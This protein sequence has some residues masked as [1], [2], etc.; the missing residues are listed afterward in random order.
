MSVL[1]NFEA[2]AGAGDTHYSVMRGTRADL[3]IRQSEATGW[4]PAL[5]VEPHDTAHDAA[6]GAVLAKALVPIAARYSGVDARRSGAAWEIVIPARWHVG[7]EAHFAQVTEQF[8][9]Y[10]KAG[11]LPEWE[12]PN[13]L[14]KYATIMKAYTMSGG[15]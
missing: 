7:H 4:Q 8:L 3:V 9:G 14:T 5:C 2:P 13:M 1:W 15:R 10:V 11:K 6:F 12:V